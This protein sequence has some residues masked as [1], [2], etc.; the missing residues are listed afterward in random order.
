[1]SD[2][3]SRRSGWRF[4]A[5][6]GVMIACMGVRIPEAL[7]ASNLR[8]EWNQGQLS[9][10]AEGVT[11]GRLL[12]EIRE[13][14]GVAFALSGDDAGKT[15]SAQ[16]RELPLTEG[17]RKVLGSL[18]HSMIFDA[19]G[20]LSRVLILGGTGSATGDPV[21]KGPGKARSTPASE[22]PEEVSASAEAGAGTTD[23]TSFGVRPPPKSLSVKPSQVDIQIRG[24][25]EIGGSVGSSERRGPSPR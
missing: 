2:F 3:L 7:A 15:V 8:V 1:M 5:G 19:Q 10:S 23:A 16:F 11:L 24:S 14:T 17:I 13:Q 18:P 25:F 21:E 6:L 4:L 22:K 20:R 12:G 9:V